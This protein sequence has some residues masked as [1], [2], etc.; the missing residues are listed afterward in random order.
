M[1]EVLH[2]VYVLV[3]DFHD[4]F[5]EQ[6]SISIASLKYRMTS[7]HITL[8][9]EKVTN[10]TFGGCSLVD[11]VIVQELDNSYS[12]IEKSRILKTMMRDVIEGDFLYIDCDTVICE[13][14]ESIK[15]MPFTSAVLDNHQAVTE[16]IEEFKLIRQRAEIL[17]YE[18]G[19]QNKH[20]NSGVLWCKDDE[21]TRQLFQLWQTLWRESREKGI[22]S[23]QP[24]LNEA[25][26]EMQGVIQELSG[27]WN[28]QLRYGIPYLAEA[29]IIHYFASNFSPNNKRMYAYLLTESKYLREMRKM[30]DIP[31]EVN[32]IIEK[33]RLAFHPAIILDTDNF[34]YRI[35]NSDIGFVCTVLYQR[36]KGIYDLLDTFCGMIRKAGRYIRKLKKV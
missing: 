30:Q 27:K 1:N 14:L 22:L 31:T 16:E 35:L 4:Y 11:N 12:M 18:V 23:D 15:K 21:Q 3:S 25:N 13:S 26:N 8:L 7:V 28:C 34:Q 29:K 17:G 36:Y 10:E 24:S 20:F 33:P 19:Y 6:M 9:T 2:V 5:Y 32:N